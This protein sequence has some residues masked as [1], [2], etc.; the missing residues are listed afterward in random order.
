MGPITT[1][2]HIWLDSRRE[3]VIAWAFQKGQ[4]DTHYLHGN[5]IQLISFQSSSMRP[6][7]KQ[8]HC[9]ILITELG[10]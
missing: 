10:S 7:E 8:F 6:K 3:G 9:K 5:Q 4:V 2:D 1:R